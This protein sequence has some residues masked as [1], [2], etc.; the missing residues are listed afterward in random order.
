[1]S[2]VKDLTGQKFGMLT[3]IEPTNQ[4]QSGS[5]VWKCQCE[6]GNI[7]FASSQNLQRGDKKSCGCITEN[8]MSG[9]QFGEFT[10][11][12]F[13]YSKGY[14]KYWKC[15]CSCG[16][17]VNMSTYDIHCG[18]R[19]H[20]R[21]HAHINPLTIDL[22]GKRFGK[23]T[24]I[25][26]LPYN[27]KFNRILWR[28]RCDCGNEKIVIGSYLRAGDVNSCGCIVSKGELLVEQ[29]L[30]SSG[31]KFD[32]Q[33]KFSDLLGNQDYLRFDFAI[34]NDDDIVGLIEVQGPQH[35]LESNVW[36]TDLLVEYDERKR[37]YCEE[38]H[39][40][41]LAVK[42]DHDYLDMDQVIKFCDSI[43]AA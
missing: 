26:K 15:R 18:K 37:R 40:P 23:L 24:V 7:T 14:H 29:W 35:W 19:L 36:H 13:A 3:A 43:L 41:L 8:D 42:Y 27:D 25:E 10:V 4:R 20:C 38:H 33:H 32:P 5:V 28:C 6:C 21:S 31:I 12:E 39:L 30:N 34:Y 17:T 11:E 16:N 2:C 22:T 1:M 9:Y